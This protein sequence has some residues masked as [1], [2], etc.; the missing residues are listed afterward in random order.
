M[1]SL[2][3]FDKTLA[4]RP[5]E[6]TDRRSIYFKTVEK[7]GVSGL[8]RLLGYNTPVSIILPVLHFGHSSMSI[9]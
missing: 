3:F 9:P 2:L 4:F 1:V 6:Q 5:L 7:E 8:P